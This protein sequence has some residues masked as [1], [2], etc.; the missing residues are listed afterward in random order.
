ME[1]KDNVTEIIRD[2][3]LI[4]D[5]VFGLRIYLT[6]RKGDLQ[7]YSDKKYLIFSGVF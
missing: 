3:E 4:N 6:G 5:Y 2:D 1:K 7:D